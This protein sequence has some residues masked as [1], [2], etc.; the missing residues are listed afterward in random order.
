M[1]WSISWIE[2]TVS[3][4]LF[5]SMLCILMLQKMLPMAWMNGMGPLETIFIVQE[6]D[7]IHFGIQD[8]LI[9]LSIVLPVI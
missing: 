7:T 4:Y 5:F 6:E 1:I 3:A 8:F 9:I 2:L